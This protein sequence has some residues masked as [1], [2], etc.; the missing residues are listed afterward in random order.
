[1]MMGIAEVVDGDIKHVSGNEAA[2]RFFGRET[3]ERELREKFVNALSLD[4]RTPLTAAKMTAQLLS[5]RLN[6]QNFIHRSSIKIAEI[7]DRADSMIQDMLDAGRI[8]AGE[9]LPLELA[10]CDLNH[11]MTETTFTVKLPLK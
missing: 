11:L 1:M 5:K 3:N 4:L 2:T 6:D 8:R 9:K 7:M 10:E